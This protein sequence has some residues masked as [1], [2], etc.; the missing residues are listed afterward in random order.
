V[1]IALGAAPPRVLRRAAASGSSCRIRHF[2]RNAGG[3]RNR[4]VLR[5]NLA[6]LRRPIRAYLLAI[7]YRLY[8]PVAVSCRISCQFA[9]SPPTHYAMS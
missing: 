5:N 2:I 6:S 9:S 8:C 7:G 4:A 1:R 3:G